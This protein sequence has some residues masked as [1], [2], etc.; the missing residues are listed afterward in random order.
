[1]KNYFKAASS[2][3]ILFISFAN[4]TADAATISYY[5]DQTNVDPLMPD[6]TNY[7]IV[8]ATGDTFGQVDFRI[9]TVP[10][11]FTQG[12]NFGIQGFGFSIVPST[13]LLSNTDFILPES[14]TVNIAPPSNVMDGFGG[15]DVLVSNGGG[16]RQD[17]L[18]FSVLGLTLDDLFEV[19]SGN[20][21]Q[22]N[23]VFAAHVADFVISDPGVTSGFIGGSTLVPVPA[24]LWLFGSGLLGLIG[25]A[26]RKARV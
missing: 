19:S 21:G 8:T 25:V 17:P 20:A 9:E 5:L 14:W 6:G 4:N 1:M 3:L 22:G 24:A 15:F 26:R 7:M 18:Q 23:V 10:G 16:N 12:V 11:A 2:V 13:N